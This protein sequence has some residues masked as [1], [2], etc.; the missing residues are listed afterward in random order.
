MRAVL[1]RSGQGR[2]G[3]TGLRRKPG[4]GLLGPDIEASQAFGEMPRDIGDRRAAPMAI[5]IGEV[6]EQIGRRAGERDFEVEREG[7]VIESGHGGDE[8][9]P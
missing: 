1:S 8:N 9:K 2:R 6:A 4:A 5:G 3:K 7:F